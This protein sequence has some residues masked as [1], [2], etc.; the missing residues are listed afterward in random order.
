[1]EVETKSRS[2]PSWVG[3]PVARHD[4]NHHEQSMSSLDSDATGD[5]YDDGEEPT[6]PVLLQFDDEHL[7][8]HYRNDTAQ[9]GHIKD[10]YMDKRTDASGDITT[11]TAGADA[12]A[13]DSP[14]QL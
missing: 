12:G 3:Q 13:S 10:L 11:A 8:E 9:L 2:Y 1:M 6:A 14:E 7:F 4:D 5:S